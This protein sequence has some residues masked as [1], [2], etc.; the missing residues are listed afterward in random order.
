MTRL[1]L[2]TPP[3][4]SAVATH[5][6]FPRVLLAIDFGSAS[7]AAARWATTHVAPD[8]DAVLL[9]VMPAR[10]ELSNDDAT[11]VSDDQ[12]LERMTP[13]VLGGLGGFGAT[14]HVASARSV[15]RAGRP[16]AALVSVANDAE[17]SLLVLGR[18]ADANRV[19]VGEP[20]VIERAARR[21]R[22]SVLVVPEGTVQAPDHIVA[23][24]DRSRFAPRVLEFARRLARMH[25]ASLTVLHVLP[26]VDGSYERVLRSGKHT[27]APGGRRKHAAPPSVPSSL[28]VAT[29]RWLVHLCRTQDIV[30]RDSIVLASG[31]P[32]REI[33]RTAAEHES[34]FVVLGL[35]GAD[36]A[37]T[38]SLGSVA[39]ELLMRGPMPVL[40]VDAA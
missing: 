11:D 30:A 33:L 35:R 37:P 16:S 17:T 18:R 21:G 24:V 19:R 32:T 14:L 15:V 6:V 20:N 31:D 22:A 27:L 8:T 3:P 2:A 38:G 28:A 9:H 23:A 5:A 39:R 25:E 13:A 40:A 12:S 7:L 4:L 10:D 29:A 36:D 1:Q 26:P 34:P